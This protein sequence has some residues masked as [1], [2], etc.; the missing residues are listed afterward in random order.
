VA[1]VGP[2]GLGAPL[3]AAQRAGVGRLGQ[4]RADPHALELLGDE[5]PAGGG[6]QRE[7]GLLSVELLQPGAQLETGGGAELAA[8]SLAG[9]GVKDVEGDLAA[10]DVALDRRLSPGRR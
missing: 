9:R 5:P 4:V 6:L 10:V 2:V 8:A 1:G 7:A 3:G